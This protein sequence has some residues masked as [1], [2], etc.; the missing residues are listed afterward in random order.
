MRRACSYRHLS[1]CGGG[2]GTGKDK[3]DTHTDTRDTGREWEKVVW[4][5]DREREKVKASKFKSK[6]TQ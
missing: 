4:K 1:S 2:N 5:R 3:K 6:G